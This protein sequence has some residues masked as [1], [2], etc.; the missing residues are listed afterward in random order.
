M[1]QVWQNF[2]QSQFAGA[3][4]AKLSA[5][6]QQAVLADLSHAGLIAVSGKDTRAFLQGQLSTDIN[7]LDAATSQVS[8]WNNAKGRVVTLLQVFQRDACIYMS[9]PAALLEPVLKRLRLYILRSKV[10]LA[11]ASDSLACF[12]LMGAAAPGLLQTCEL[13]AP[14]ANN[15][16]AQQGNVQIIRL[17]GTQPRFA[18][19]AAPEDLKILWKQLKTN[20][21]IPAPLETW[22]LGRILARVPAIHPETT[23]HF[24]AQMLSLEELGAIHFKK[25]CYLGQEVI[26]RAHYRGAVKRHLHRAQCALLS[27]IIP[28]AT[29]YMRDND[30]AAAEIVDA[31][32]DANNV[33]QL[34]IVLQDEFANAPLHMNGSAVSLAN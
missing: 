23:E 19:Y 22:E 32:R 2:I 11:D 17:H 14:P 26:A 16:I 30:Q 3:A 27:S 25:G 31:C 1:N 6:V 21:A 12:G 20:G 28:G 13:P 34:L 15:S 9:L 10:T 4:Y 5:D 18:V 24:V 7:A 29:V 33:W 8:S